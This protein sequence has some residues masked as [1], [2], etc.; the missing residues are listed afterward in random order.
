M[1][2]HGDLL[3]TIL[4]E[5]RAE[6]SLVLASLLTEQTAQR[7]NINALCVQ[8]ARVEAQLSSLC[9]RLDD[10]REHHDKVCIDIAATDGAMAARV[11]KIEQSAAWV[12]AWAAGAAAA[13]AAIFG[14]LMWIVTNV[15]GR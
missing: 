7:S 4:S 6:Q 15:G 12:R 14:T 13:V 3:R 8:C 1:T 5:H 2:D 9:E 10:L 11:G